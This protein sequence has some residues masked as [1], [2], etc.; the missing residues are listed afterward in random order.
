[1]AGLKHA[2][3]EEAEAVGLPQGPAR[4]RRRAALRARCALLATDAM[5]GPVINEDPDPA[6]IDDDL[7]ALM[8]ISCLRSSHC[9]VDIVVLREEAICLCRAGGP[10]PTWCKP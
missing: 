2:K 8:F 7:L 3:T 1:L 6:R 4:H 5:L 10:R 9:L